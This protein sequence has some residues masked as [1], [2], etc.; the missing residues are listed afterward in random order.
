MAVG[1]APEDPGGPF[2]MSMRGATA[3]S[4]EGGLPDLSLPHQRETRQTK[5]QRGR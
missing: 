3:A 1:A 2:A 5:H 4:A